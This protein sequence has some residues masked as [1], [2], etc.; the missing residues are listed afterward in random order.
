MNT[1]LM[2]AAVIALGA[3]AG[4][5][6]DTCNADEVTAAQ[7]KFDTEYKKGVK[8]TTARREALRLGKEF[9]E[10][11][12]AN[13]EIAKV[14]VDWLNIN[15][16]KKEQELKDY[17]AQV[18]KDRAISRFNAGL[19]AKNW[20]EVYASGRDLLNKYPED[21]RDIE[22]MLATIGFDETYNK[23]NLK[24]ND[25]ALRF[26]KA[27]IADLEA[28]KKFGPKYGVPNDFVYKTKENAL[29]WM[30]LIVGYLTQVGK[31]DKVAA[32]PYLYK[33]TQT[34]GADTMKN[35][36]PYEFIGAY[37]FD[38]LNK[39]VDEIKALEASQKDTDTEEVAKQ[40]FDAIKAKVALANGTAERAMD[41]FSRAYTLGQAQA[42]KAKMKKNVEDAYKVRFGKVEGLDSWIAG[43]AAKAFPN[44]LS[45]ITPISDPEPAKTT[46]GTNV[47]VGNG[48]G[49]GTANG[50]GVGT[51]NGTGVGAA[52]GTGL[53]TPKGTGTM[54]TTTPKASTTATTTTVVKPKP[55]AKKPAKKRGNR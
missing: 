46:V 9:I 41:A 38:E 21:F 49:V 17:E 48:T 18:E 34:V 40:K 37:Y 19:N 23:N 51:A 22:L 25:E 52:S 45:P 42:Y 7:D 3:V 24:Y 32:A 55:A 54:T 29:G 30:N 8:D 43:V 5:A 36:L 15:V 20:D 11:Y 14:R 44:P 50:T 31:K 47:G 1:G 26:A 53:G 28:N 10:K 4:V 12:S 35:P 39:L 2:L 6:Q 16:P 13:C 27:A 33:A